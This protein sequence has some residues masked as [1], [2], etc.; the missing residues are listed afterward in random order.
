MSHANA[1]QTLWFVCI[2]AQCYRSHTCEVISPTAIRPRIC[3]CSP[4]TGPPSCLP[5]VPPHCTHPRASPL[6]QLV[7]QLVRQPI[8]QLVYQQVLQLVQQPI[9]FAVGG[10]AFHSGAIRCD[11][12]SVRRVT[13]IEESIL[14]PT[15]APHLQ[16]TKV[17]F[18][19]ACKR[20]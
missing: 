20:V 13:M 14:T 3:H 19:L 4:P 16:E 5:L 8:L 6:P 17:G 12:P 7:L 18:H 1:N 10:S 11:A 2:R 9:V 15:P